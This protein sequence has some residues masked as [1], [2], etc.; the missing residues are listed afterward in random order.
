MIEKPTLSSL[1]GDLIRLDKIIKLSSKIVHEDGDARTAPR[2][3]KAL[4]TNMEKLKAVC[5]S[6]LEADFT[7]SYEE[8][9]DPEV[10]F[11]PYIWEVVVCV[12]TASTIDWDTD[13]IQV[14]PLL[15]DLDEDIN[16][17]VE[18]DR[19]IMQGFTND[20]ADVV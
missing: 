9:A 17:S 3:F 19:G 4:E 10:F 15:D 14:F 13:R 12:V 2:A 1:K 16:D 8:E 18:G 20:V 11:V 6:S 5:D 7:F